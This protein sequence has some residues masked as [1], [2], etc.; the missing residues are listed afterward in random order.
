MVPKPAIQRKPVRRS[1]LSSGMV[2]RARDPGESQIP[3]DIGE[4]MDANTYHFDEL[5]GPLSSLLWLAGLD[6]LEAVFNPAIAL[7][8]KVKTIPINVGVMWILEHLF[9]KG[10]LPESLYDRYF[11]ENH[12]P[13]YRHTETCHGQLQQGIEDVT[14]CKHL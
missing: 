7:D 3:G 14:R 5:I 11:F 1:R 12:Q 9:G 2:Q 4:H 8:D 13:L 6:G 10:K